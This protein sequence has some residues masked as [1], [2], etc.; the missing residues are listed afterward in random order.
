[1]IWM[2]AFSVM[3]GLFLFYAVLQSLQGLQCCKVLF[4]S[5]TESWVMKSV[6][7]KEGGRKYLDKVDRSKHESASEAVWEADLDLI[8]T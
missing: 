7:T 3:R 8:L 1:M 4:S 5:N 6:G 2:K